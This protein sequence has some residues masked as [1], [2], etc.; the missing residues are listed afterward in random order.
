MELTLKQW[1]ALQEVNVRQLSE[2]SGVSEATICHIRTGKFKPR[3]ETLEK[4]CKALGIRM[5]D[6][7][8]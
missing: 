2:L 1:M 7:K 6:V 4:L 8:L 5:S 3:I